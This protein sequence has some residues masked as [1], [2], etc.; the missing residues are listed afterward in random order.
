MRRHFLPFLSHS[1]NFFHFT[2]FCAQA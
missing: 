2:D 1:T